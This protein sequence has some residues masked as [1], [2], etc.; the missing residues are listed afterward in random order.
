M[1]PSSAETSNKEVNLH[2]L[3]RKMLKLFYKWIDEQRAD[4]REELQ[5]MDLNSCGEK[6]L[7][8]RIRSNNNL[9]ESFIQFSKERTGTKGEQGVRQMIMRWKRMLKHTQ[10]KYNN[11]EQFLND[12]LTVQ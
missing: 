8:D 7:R 3:C 11:S 6:D 9:R 5:L 2:P 1:E 12:L 4:L 10:D